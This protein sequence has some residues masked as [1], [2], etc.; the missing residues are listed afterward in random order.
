MSVPHILVVDDE[1]PNR[2]LLERLLTGEGWSVT[3]A[4]DGE[5]ALA[6]FAESPPDVVLMD[7]RMPGLDGYETT[8]RLK[9]ASSGLVPV[10]FVTALTED[11]DL[12]ACVE[13]GGDD[14]V[15]KPIRRATLLAKVR[16]WLRLAEQQR[17]IE[18][19][20][21][22]LLA[23][24]AERR[25]EHRL[26]AAMLAAATDHEPHLPRGFAAC[27][28]PMGEIGGDVL[29]TGVTPRGTHV[30][31]VGDF[32]G[33]GVPAAL[34]ILPVA[35][36]FRRRLARGDSSAA[37]LA[38]LDAQLARLLPP[39]M[40]LAA[41]L[42]EVSAGCERVRVWNAGLPPVLLCGADG[43]VRHRFAAT[44]PPLGITRAGS[45]GVEQ[46]LPLAHGDR[47]VAF[48]DGLIGEAEGGV[49]AA[50][51]LAEQGLDAVRA[52]LEALPG[53][54]ADDAL[55]LEIRVDDLDH[56]LREEPAP[57]APVEVTSGRWHLALTVD[58]RTLA[59]GN[60]LPP[61]NDLLQRFLGEGPLAQ[62]TAVVA[63]ELFQNAVDY[64]LLGLEAGQRDDP[65]GLERYH[66]ERH[67]R[68]RAGDGMGRVTLTVHGAGSGDAPG[69]IVE[70]SQSGPGFDHAGA[71]ER[72]RSNQQMQ[73]HGR[74]LR[75]ASQ[76]SGELSFSAG[77]RCVRA[78][79]GAAAGREG[80][81]T[82]D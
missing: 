63:G 32:T 54:P 16:A 15:V 28:R 45:S 3:T 57:V 34:G 1:Q 50:E 17:T 81:D 78:R 41:A 56:I 60:P 19:Q 5:A 10:L 58:A 74:G 27:Q 22:T 67:A 61:L 51:A 24:D 25:E 46:A 33:H 53:P 13:C 62:D 43:R 79:L 14:F 12:A 9:A 6:R 77:G 26:A 21:D 36:D 72:A 64:G 70:V 80:A 71:L 68:M 75:L 66:A 59:G 11:R 73:A 20:R 48:S 49:A 35:G 82:L 30:C 39:Q 44:R 38:A 37:I 31:L 47:L 69:V 23:R 4:E 8:R 18:A 40:F 7:V 52:H 65:A 76:L 55:V 42:I 2:R 29:L